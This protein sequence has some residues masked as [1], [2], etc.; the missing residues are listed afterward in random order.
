[1]NINCADKEVWVLIIVLP[2][3]MRKRRRNREILIIRVTRASTI[4]TMLITIRHIELNACNKHVRVY[5][6]PPFYRRGN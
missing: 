1:M 2:L 3:K 6:P 4:S 5:L